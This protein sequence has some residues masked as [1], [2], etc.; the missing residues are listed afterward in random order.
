MRFTKKQYKHW[1]HL[2]STL[3]DVV[4][5]SSEMALEQQQRFQVLFIVFINYLCVIKGQYYPRDYS[6]YNQYDQYNPYDP[7]NQ[8]SDP[9][10]RDPYNRDRDPFNR[11]YST[12]TFNDRRYG[13]YQP[14]YYAGGHPGD[15]R[16]PGQDERFSYDRVSNTLCF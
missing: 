2:L 13:Q 9:Y 15:P 5:D 8:N 11:D 6:H 12:Y 14:N 3:R 10:N 7:Y 16:Y 1:P 4:T